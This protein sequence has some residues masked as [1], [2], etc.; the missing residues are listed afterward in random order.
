MV[1][2]E[3][4]ALAGLRR[5]EAASVCIESAIFGAVWLHAALKRARLPLLDCLQLRLPVRYRSDQKFPA[6]RLQFSVHTP[7]IRAQIS[8]IACHVHQQAD[9]PSKYPSYFP[10]LIV[11]HPAEVGKPAGH[12]PVSAIP[13]VH[14]RPPHQSTDMR[15][16]LNGIYTLYWVRI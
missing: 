10:P 4:T 8:G 6:R 13:A 3:R 16:R 12:F 1:R 11:Q 2:R 7:C 9:T 5:S 14:S 15:D